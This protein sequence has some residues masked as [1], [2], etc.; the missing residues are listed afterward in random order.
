MR[1]L[2]EVKK[3]DG[4]V[5]SESECRV[6]DPTYL[7]MVAGLKKGGVVSFTARRWATRPLSPNQGMVS[8]R[9]AK[10][11]SEGRRRGEPTKNQ[12]RTCFN[13]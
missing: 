10:L 1:C 6:D 11:C 5:K 9:C 7:A 13:V 12:L 3:G 4:Y 8:P 2:R